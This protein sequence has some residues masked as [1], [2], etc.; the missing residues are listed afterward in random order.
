MRTLFLAAISETLLEGIVYAFLASGAVA[1][2]GLIVYAVVVFRRVSTALEASTTTLRSMAALLDGVAQAV[3]VLDNTLRDTH[4][5]LREPQRLP[6]PCPP[7]KAGC[8]CGGTFKPVSSSMSGDTAI[9]SLR[10]DKCGD[11]TSVPLANSA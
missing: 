9:L 2:L 7:T 6:R 8:P 11:T 10:C 4:D 3:T 1:I 5:T